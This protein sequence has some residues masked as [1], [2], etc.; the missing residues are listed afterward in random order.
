M[1]FL[2]QLREFFKQQ[3]P[4]RRL[5]WAGIAIG[6]V[7]LFVKEPGP[8]QH[9]LWQ[10]FW[11]LGHLFLF[12]GVGL[13]ASERYLRQRP[14]LSLFKL[15]LG[16]AFIGWIIEV[17]QGMTGRDY[18]LEDVAADTL[19]MALGL[20]IGGFR[21]LSK[22]RW[23]YALLAILL[24]GGLAVK[25]KPT[26][27]SAV[28][29]IAAARQFPVLADFSGFA[30]HLQRDRF[31]SISA[32]LKV[33]AGVLEVNLLPGDFP[34]FGL[35]DFPNDWRGWHV[36]VIDIVNPASAPLAITCRIH[37]A[38]HAARGNLFAD[39]FNGRFILQPGENRLRIDLQA[40]EHAPAGRLLD[41][42]E[43][44]APACFTH[45]LDRPQTLLLR[46]MVLE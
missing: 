17:I 28:D 29:A 1:T 24:L 20:A 7:L 4:L 42:S 35:D 11:D 22:P 16:T 21:A 34:G 31:T 23:G 37:D 14:W 32:W 39:R 5:L 15:L 8:E 41:M 27:Y 26:V 6:C 45:H 33:D 43:V 13:F 38:Q 3:S 12:G 19:G 40:V 44:R 46:S 18:S 10:E 9:R 25:V 2:Q 36:L 30:P